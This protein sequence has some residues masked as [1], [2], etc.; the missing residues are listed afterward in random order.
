M[1]VLLSWYGQT[2]LDEYLNS[3]LVEQE[4]KKRDVALT[5]KEISD[6]LQAIRKSSRDFDAQ[7]AQQRITLPYFTN[8]LK[9]NLLM[10]RMI[11]QKPELISDDDLDEARL[12]HIVVL[13]KPAQNQAEAATNEAAARAKIEKAAAEIKGGLDFGEAARKYSEDT[14]T[15][16]RGGQME[17]FARR[18]G[19]TKEV[20][21]A[22]FAMKPG[23]V[24]NL[25]KTSYGYHLIQ[26]NELKPGKSLSD[27]QKA[28]KKMQAFEKSLP[29]YMESWFSALKA[30]SKIERAEKIE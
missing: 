30:R 11:P 4:A 1:K 19:P 23:E 25:I 18:S 20:E 10:R 28:Q 6:Q 24:S 15:A 8:R 5:D 29:L 13:V 12:S 9:I 2:A 14:A 26:L 7:L 16:S 17:P 21:D 27:E 22:A 3:R